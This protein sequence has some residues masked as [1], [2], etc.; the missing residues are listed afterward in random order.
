[1]KKYRSQRKGPL[2]G[3]N[4]I[5][6]Y[7]CA[8]MEFMVKMASN[9]TNGTKWSCEAGQRRPRAA[10]ATAVGAGAPPGWVKPLERPPDRPFAYSV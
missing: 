5:A 10:N 9:G 4:R 1:M 6:P 2:E 3:K 7:A 8:Y